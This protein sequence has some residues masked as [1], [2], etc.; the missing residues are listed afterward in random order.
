MTIGVRAATPGDL[1]A[2]TALLR[3]AKLPRDGVAEAFEDFIVA[4][5]AGEIVGAAGLEIR[6][7][8]ALLRSVV[9]AP[10]AQGHAVG[11]Q[12]TARAIADARARA[13]DTIWLLTISAIDFFPR[14]GFRQVARE[15]VPAA[16][17]ATVEFHHACPASAAVMVRRAQPLRVLVLCTANVARSQLAEA[18]L[19]H[20]GGD[21]V[22]V[23]SA[24]AVPGRAPHPMAREV[25]AERGIIWE[26]KRSKGIDEVAAAGWDL[27]ITVCDAARDACPVMPGATMVH[28]GLEDPVSVGADQDALGRA[29]RTTADA[30]DHRF[31]E[32][33]RLPLAILDRDELA[34]EASAIHARS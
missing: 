26:G 32:L 30:L 33:L 23:A 2:V 3:D 34:R 14:F 13:L 8:D 18:I 24:G 29:F 20:R 10:A 9:V 5:S 15:K 19:Q 6:G 28:W 27:V 22:S 7:R 4:E 25:L 12:L 17:Q 21:L 1:P 11:H 16:L 31:A